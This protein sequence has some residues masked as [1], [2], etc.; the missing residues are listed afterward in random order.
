METL[1][2]IPAAVAA[3][4]PADQLA[5]TKRNLKEFSGV[6]QQLATALEKC[7]KIGET[8]NMKEHPLIF[9][10]FTGGNDI[11][12]C[13]YDQDD[14]MYGYGILNGDLPNSEWGYFSLS[15]LKKISHYNIEYFSDEK[16]IEAALYTAYPKY[17]KNL[18]SMGNWLDDD[19]QVK[20]YIVDNWDFYEGEGLEQ[21]FKKWKALPKE[22]RTEKELEHICKTIGQVAIEKNDPPEW[23]PVV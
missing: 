11:F 2:I 3:L 4:I 19:E 20:N 18:Q 1:K 15:A 14:L 21:A 22:Q 5:I 7:P 13:E 17:F 16:S 12:I 8:G 23:L 10:Y 9:H 6:I